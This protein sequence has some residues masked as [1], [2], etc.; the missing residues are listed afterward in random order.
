MLQQAVASALVPFA[1]PT[2]VPEDALGKRIREAKVQDWREIIGIV[3]ILR[4]P[5]WPSP[6]LTALGREDQACADPDRYVLC[7]SVIRRRSCR[8]FRK[9]ALDTCMFGYQNLTRCAGGVSSQRLKTMDTKYQCS[10][11][12]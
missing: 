5:F 8:L 2:C 10:K 11:R 6:T 3:G 1:N 9:L 4:D 7:Y 12:M